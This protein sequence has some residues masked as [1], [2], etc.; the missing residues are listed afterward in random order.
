MTMRIT[1]TL[2]LIMTAVT[3]AYAQNRTAPIESTTKVR[4]VRPSLS[5]LTNEVDEL[6]QSLLELEIAVTKANT[7]RLVERNEDFQKTSEVQNENFKKTLE[8][9]EKIGQIKSDLAAHYSSLNNPLSQLRNEFDNRGGQLLQFRRDLDDAAARVNQ[10]EAQIRED[11]V[12]TAQQIE[13]LTSRLNVLEARIQSISAQHVQKTE[14]ALR[15]EEL[16][17]RIR[18][19]E[20][21]NQSLL[22]RF[23]VAETLI[24]QLSEQISANSER[25]IL[26]NRDALTHLS[27]VEQLEAQILSLESFSDRLD[28]LAAK[29]LEL[30]RKVFVVNDIGSRLEELTKD[31]YLL[32]IELLKLESETKKVDDSSRLTAEDLSAAVRRVDELEIVQLK[33]GDLSSLRDRLKLLEGKIISMEERSAFPESLPDTKD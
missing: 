16:L 2:V 31:T 25:L 32:Q 6:K 9:T 21:A 29:D 10:A 26:A 20:E 3:I 30:D 11:G 7:A 27:R 15:E 13:G 28:I 22:Q 18:H 12:S 1:F 4:E 5:Q 8:L 33:L 23:Q 19:L 24:Q 14:F 17:T